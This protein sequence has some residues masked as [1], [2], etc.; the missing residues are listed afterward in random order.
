MLH[1]NRKNDE[2]QTPNPELDLNLS[3]SDAKTKTL[4]RK[5]CHF[6]VGTNH[7][8]GKLPSFLRNREA[9]GRAPL[10]KAL[11]RTTAY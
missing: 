9:T 3:L 1:T 2:L 7:I 8:Q 4:S 11:P 6:M 10:P 5:L